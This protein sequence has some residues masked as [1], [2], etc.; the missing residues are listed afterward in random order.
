MEDNLKIEAFVTW[1]CWIRDW[2]LRRRGSQDHVMSAVIQ[3]L[4]H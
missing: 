2:T 1:E 3:G 4:L